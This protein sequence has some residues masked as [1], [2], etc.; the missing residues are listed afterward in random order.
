MPKS[1]RAEYI[2]ITFFNFNF[3]T[4]DGEPPVKAASSEH[5]YPDPQ[6]F[7]STL[8]DMGSSRMTLNVSCDGS[9]SSQSITNTAVTPSLGTDPVDTQ[10]LNETVA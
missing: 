3:L 9:D 1:L 4:T 10:R 2:T 7:D 8:L 5:N 6:N